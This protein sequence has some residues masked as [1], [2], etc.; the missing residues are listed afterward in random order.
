[1]TAADKI[2]GLRSNS[3][4]DPH[5]GVHPAA[6]S[7]VFEGAV[8][9]PRGPPRDARAGS[10]RGEA[11]GPADTAA[12]RARS[13]R[14]PR[15]YLRWHLPRGRGTTPQNTEARPRHQP[16][17]PFATPLPPPYAGRASR[18]RDHV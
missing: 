3:T 2:S 18:V 8:V 16:E 9:P 17:S 14:A 13:E 12:P 5:V 1:M 4:T 11:I 6:V 15:P 10:T 7:P